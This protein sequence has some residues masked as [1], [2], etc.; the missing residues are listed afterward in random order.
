[1]T[2]ENLIHRWA[3]AVHEGD[4]ETVVDRHA[5]DIAARI[6]SGAVIIEFGSGTSLKTRVLLDELEDP[7]AYVPVDLSRAQLVAASRALALRFPDLRVLPV[8]ADFTRSFVLPA[9]TQSS[10][11]RV[12]YLAGATLGNFTPQAATDLL[13]RLA[14]SAAAGRAAAREPA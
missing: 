3:R 8:C 11:R 14:C 10:R 12:I 5:A 7:F 6:G 4:L 13:R 9:D 1:M 2:T